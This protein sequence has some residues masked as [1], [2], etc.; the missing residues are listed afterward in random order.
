MADHEGEASPLS[1]GADEP[2][3]LTG[4]RTAPGVREENYWFQ[5]HV[6]A[7]R[8]AAELVAGHRTMDAGCGEGYGAEI[9]AGR[10]SSVLGVDLEP[11]IVGRATERYPSARFETANLVSMHYDDDSFGAIVS[12]QVIEHLHT[13]HEF[14]AECKRV[15][16]PGGVLI[17]STPNRLTFSPDGLRNPFHAFEFAP[18]ELRA[19]IARPFGQIELHGVFHGL[20]LRALEFFLRNPLPERLIGQ[21]A[22]EWPGWLAERV[23]RVRAEDFRIRARRIEESLDLIAVA[24]A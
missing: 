3:P 8:W 11:A 4:E 16:E 7:Y 2:L 1:F 20:G 21:P 17:V 9:L 15:L 5:R 6:F 12:L 14:L 18:D 22:Y 24:R 19:A 23:A 10:A 13:P